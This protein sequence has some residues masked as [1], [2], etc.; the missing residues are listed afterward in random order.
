MKIVVTGTRG[1]PDI[2][3]GVE[4]HCE[5]LYPRIAAMGHNV[6]VIRRSCY[7]NDS[8]RVSEY[9]GVKLADVYAPRKKSLE[10]I[11]HTA[12]AVIKARRMN[13]DILHIHAVGPSLMVPFA[14]IL[15]LKVV[16]TNHGPDYDR[17]KWGKLAKNMLRTGERWGTKWSNKVIV[18]SSVIAGIL[19]SNYG[20]EDVDLIYNGVNKPVKS[21]SVDFLEK[22]GIVP[23][24]YILA[25]GRFVK[26]KGFHDLIEA[27]SRLDCGDIQLVIAG[28]A[29]HPDPYSTELK[30][31]AA[32]A[33]VILTGFIKGEELNQVL[34]NAA[35]F[36][37]PSYHEG[38]PI[39]LLEAMSYDLDVLVSDIPA[40]RLPELESSDFFN[41]GD[42]DSLKKA[43]DRKIAA[44]HRREYDLASYNWDNIARQTVD[45]YKSVL[46]H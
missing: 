17:Q 21:V 38:L 5:N 19:K 25:L 34:S 14:R 31:M 7:V 10:A 22:K 9:K 4:T 11:L 8:N 20:R 39:A 29:D 18:I 40:N 32:D 41:T 6:T 1:I 35:L 27:Y 16:M 43:L 46:A 2:Q 37:L 42:V 36:V 33:G 3:G 13:P 26:E 45:V 28:D 24:R 23:G 15:G 30:R 12:L 44:I